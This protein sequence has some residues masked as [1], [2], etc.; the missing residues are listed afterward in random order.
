MR[1][2]DQQL[3]RLKQALGL[4]ED[5]AVAAALGMSKAAFADRKRRDAFPADK[6][7]ALASDRPEMALDVRYVLTGVSEA[8]DSRLQALKEATTLALALG[9]PAREGEFVRDVVYGAKIA[10]AELVR[11]TIENYA[12]ERGSAAAASE[13]KS[14]R[15]AR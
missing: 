12:R 2:F 1:A 5:Q 4:V 15:R 14:R 6:L 9:L 8:L 10:N 7:K 3:L 11:E 13:E